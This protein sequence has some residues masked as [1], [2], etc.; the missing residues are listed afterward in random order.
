MLLEKQEKKFKA[1]YP[2]KEET[3]YTKDGQRIDIG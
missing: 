3:Q 2:Y 1:N